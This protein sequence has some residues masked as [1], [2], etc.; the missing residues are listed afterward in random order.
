MNFFEWFALPNSLEVDH[1]DLKRRFYARSKE[2]HPDFHT[3]SDTK[4]QLE[5]LQ[6][7]SLNNRAYQTL[8]DFDSTLKYVLEIHGQ[9]DEEG[10]Q[11]PEEYLLEM[12]ELNELVMDLQMDFDQ[13]KYDLLHQEIASQNS[14]L[15]ASVSL[16]VEAED[17]STFSKEDWA[18]LREYYLKKRYLHR[19]N[20]NFLKTKA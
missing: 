11:I 8:S 12:M 7:A 2:L 13:Q 5:L 3:N 18:H 20:E 6:K 10:Q 15:D 19:L 1:A 9:L 14:R 4:T 16:L 17:F